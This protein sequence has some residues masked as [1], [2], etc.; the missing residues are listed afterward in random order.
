MKPWPSESILQRLKPVI[1]L[2]ESMYAD[3]KKEIIGHLYDHEQNS[4][5]DRVNSGFVF[6]SEA[7]ALD[8]PNGMTT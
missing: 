8:A 1:D 5:D 6:D 7:L 3:V 2:V 4:Q